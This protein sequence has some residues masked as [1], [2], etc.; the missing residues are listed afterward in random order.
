MA[1]VK[2]VKKVGYKILKKTVAAHW[3][4]LMNW[5]GLN[6]SEKWFRIINCTQA[7]WLYRAFH[8]RKIAQNLLH[9]KNFTEWKIRC[10]P[11]W[12]IRWFQAQ[13]DKTGHNINSKKNL[14]CKHLQLNGANVTHFVFYLPYE[15]QSSSV[16]FV[17]LND[18][19]T[20]R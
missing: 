9:G 18:I 10:S 11:K 1:S 5:F 17:Y 4:R 13:V 14:N 8:G 19:W 16:C 20:D 7:R 2:R 6:L 12:F 15:F 3:I